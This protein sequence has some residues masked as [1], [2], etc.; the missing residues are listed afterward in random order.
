MKLSY[1]TDTHAM[2]KV[3]RADLEAMRPG[4]TNFLDYK[5]LR[6]GVEV[7]YTPPRIDLVNK[8]ADPTAHDRGV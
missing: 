2:H 4:C 5:S 8:L 3:T 6:N 7:P 1:Q